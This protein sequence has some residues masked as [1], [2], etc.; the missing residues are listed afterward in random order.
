[1]DPRPDPVDLPALV[2]GAS[3][4]DTPDPA[5]L[6]ALVHRAWPAGS[7]GTQPVARDWVRRWGPHRLAAPVAAC[8]CAVGRCAWCN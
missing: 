4:P 1:M 8:G 3:T 6:R 2:R 5:S 7:D